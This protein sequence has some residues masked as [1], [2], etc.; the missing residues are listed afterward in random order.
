MDQG[1]RRSP[2]LSQL[3]VREVDV[4]TLNS[5]NH[6][7]LGSLTAERSAKAEYVSALVHHELPDAWRPETEM[8]S[9]TKVSATEEKV[10]ARQYRTLG[11][12]SSSASS[13]ARATTT[14]LEI[15]PT[16]YR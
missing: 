6:I 15:L 4:P 14:T 13:S 1:W 10:P 2:V 3:C 5:I 12:F 9:A 7:A 8:S 11:K 16:E